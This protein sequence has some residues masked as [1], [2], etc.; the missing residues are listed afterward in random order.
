MKL[1]AF[2]YAF[3][4]EKSVQG[5]LYL[6]AHGFNDVKVLAAPFKKLNIP[7]SQIRI[8]PK[9]KPL[10]PKDV[11]KA[12]NYDYVEIDHD[13]VNIL[14]HTHDR[15]LGVILGARILK[16]FLVERFDIINMHPGLCPRNRGLDNIKNAILFN[17][18]QAV[19]CH[20]VDK[21]IDRGYFIASKITDVFMDDTLLDIY[22]RNLNDQFHLM[23]KCINHHLI[24]SAK[25][26]HR[27]AE[28]TYFK[29]L[30]M[31][32]DR[33]MLKAFTRYKQNYE[34][35]CQGYR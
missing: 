2:T 31:A 1:A 35:I 28:G 25:K 11:A 14:K 9:I 23:V 7:H 12:L 21:Y 30:T 29:P 6:K 8:T 27:Q 10:H 17:I 22:L 13:E 33:R 16:P 19:T 24:A 20:L 34:Q 18:P 32:E 26:S 15:Q 3:E 5:L 4:H